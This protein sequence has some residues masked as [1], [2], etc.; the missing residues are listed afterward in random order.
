MKKVCYEEMLP[1]EAVA[2]RTE[3]PVAYLPIGTIEWHGLHNAIGLDTLKVKSLC[4][5][6]AEAG[7]GVVMPPL[8]WGEHREIQLMEVNPDWG[9]AVADSMKLPRENF[10]RGY[11]GGKTIEEQAHFYNDLLFHTYHQ[12]ASLGFKAIVILCGHYPLRVYADF[13]SAIF[14]RES[15]VRISAVTE[16]LLL[17]SAEFGNQP[18][19]HA[20]KLETSLMMALYP[21]LVD[22]SRLPKSPYASIVGVLG[23]DPRQASLEFGKKAVQQITEGLVAKA[24]DLLKSLDSPL[25]SHLSPNR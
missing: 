8:W 12:I 7:G 22:I 21:D 9:E 2:A 13:T 25:Y 17:D 15:P 24:N 3:K 14:M 1:H 5:L 6:A 19:D 20:G 11:M 10:K 23:E 4:A 18:G 16:N